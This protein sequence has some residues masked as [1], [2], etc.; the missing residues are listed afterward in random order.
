MRAASEEGHGG[1]GD[2]VYGG[3]QR[4]SKATTV[5]GGGSEEMQGQPKEVGGDGD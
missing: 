5:V 4:W 3:R 1:N 2:D